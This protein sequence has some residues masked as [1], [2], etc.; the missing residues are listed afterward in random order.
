VR[1]HDLACD[2]VGRYRMSFYDGVIVAAA[3][4]AGCTT[5]Y[6]EDMQHG[7]KVETAMIRNPFTPTK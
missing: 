4:L 7:Q 5:V 2:L 6:S 3:I 1:T